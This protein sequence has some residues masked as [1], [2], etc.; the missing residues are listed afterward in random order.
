[1]STE[2]V[3]TNAV[4]TSAV[5]TEAGSPNES[6]AR[7]IALVGLSGTGKSTIAPLLA[8]RLG[9]G[10]SVDLDRVIEGQFGR[11][12]ESIFEEDGE[13]AFR[14]AESDAL[15]QA[16]AGPPVV[17]ATGGGVVLDRENRSLLKSDATVVWLRASPALLAS[18]LS[19]TTEARPLLAGDPQF[20]LV[21]LAAER[22]A[23]YN[24][25]ADHIVDVEG[26]DVAEVVAEVLQGL[27]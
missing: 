2:A 24:E 27:R 23:L 22:E 13:G 10:A 9:F 26:L 3:S 25:V 21:R 19:D 14:D 7:S 11:S 5:P 17:I 16:L 8:S 20:A 6:T 15:A 1:M 4:S 18:R 12:V